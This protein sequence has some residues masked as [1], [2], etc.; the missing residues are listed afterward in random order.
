MF[1]L[2]RWVDPG[3]VVVSTLYTFC[4]DPQETVFWRQEPRVS[5]DQTPQ[6]Q[7]LLESSP[8]KAHAVEFTPP[9]SPPR[10]NLFAPPI[11]HSSQ[12]YGLEQNITSHPVYSH[13]TWAPQGV[14]A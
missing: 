9:P 2:F 10:Y 8:L 7:Q 14:V 12:S 11:Q 1:S 6:T 4:H 5:K 13:A 3:E